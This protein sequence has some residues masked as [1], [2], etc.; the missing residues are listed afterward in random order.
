MRQFYLTYHDDAILYTQCR[1]L[2]W[3]HNRLIMRVP[4]AKARDLIHNVYQIQMDMYIR[5]FDDLKRRPDDNP[6]IEDTHR[7]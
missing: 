6:T 1:E 5:M 4:D 3:S 2:P 7:G